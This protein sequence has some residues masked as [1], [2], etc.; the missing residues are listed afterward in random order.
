VALPVREFSV[1]GPHARRERPPRGD[2]LDVVHD[3][4]DH[5]AVHGVP[6]RLTDRL[7][8]EG[9]HLVVEVDRL[10]PEARDLRDLET[11]LGAR[12]GD[13]LRR[14]LVHDVD[15][16]GPHRG[17]ADRVVGDRPVDDLVEV[18]ERCVPIPVEALEREMVVLHPLDEAER[19]GPDR[20]ARV[21]LP[22]LLDGGPRP[23]PVHRRH[24]RIH[25]DADG[26]APHLPR[27]RSRRTRHEDQ[28]GQH[29]EH[30]WRPHRFLLWVTAGDRS[31]AQ[32]VTW[33]PVS[34]SD[35]P[36]IR[37]ELR[38][39]IQQ[40]P[41]AAALGIQYLDLRRGYGRVRL[42]L[43]PHMVNFQRYPH[44]S[45]IFTL[46]DV[47]FGAACNSHGEAAV[48]PNGTIAFLDAVTPDATLIAEGREKKQGRRAGFYEIEVT[49]EGGA[50]RVDRDD[51][52]RR[53]A[54]LLRC[55]AEPQGGAVPDALGAGPR[56]PAEP[57]LHPRD[58]GLLA[59]HA[60]ARLDRQQRGPAARGDHPRDR[61]SVG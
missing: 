42:R 34:A 38:E 19:P 32:V 20:V 58:L 59:P 61:A 15:L 40:D 12:G 2:A 44:G 47:A 33:E 46:A 39:R 3:A 55:A 54:L 51:A 27:R 29:P 60:P 43:Q 52:A 28:G 45:V 53:P 25:A 18:R 22:V 57:R 30:H 5:G 26:P 14:D 41:W 13:V 10:P 16:P 37:A 35:Y 17:E 49:T 21:V 7:H 11:A 23:L 56:R 50:R 31:R 6:D 1:L 48:A 9:G 4:L 36:E 8:V 24:V